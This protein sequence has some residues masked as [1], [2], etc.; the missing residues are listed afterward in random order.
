MCAQGRRTCAA[1]PCWPGCASSPTSS[2]RTTVCVGLIEDSPREVVLDKLRSDAPAFAAKFDRLVADCGHRGPGETELEQPRLRRCAGTVAALGDGQHPHRAMR[3][4]RLQCST[5]LGRAL[6]RFA[7]AAIERR[8]RGRDVCMRITHE[9][10]LVLREWGRRLAERG[11]LESADDVHYLSMD[12]IYYPPADSKDLVARRRAERSGWRHWTSRSISAN[13][14]RRTARRGRR[15]R[16]VSGSGRL[17]GHCARPGAHHGRSPTTTS[18]P[19]RCWSPTSPTPGGLLSSAAP[20]R[21]SPI[22]A[23]TMSH[24]AIVAREF[25]V[26]AVVNTA[27]RHSMP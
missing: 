23:V 11:T 7:V 27:D 14:G 20:P 26:P 1:P 2:R 22:S 16:V 10:R 25:G 13:R 18:S 15:R 6:V 3:L 9:L 4:P 21:S 17:A 24:A 19:A 5:P 12:E 8:E